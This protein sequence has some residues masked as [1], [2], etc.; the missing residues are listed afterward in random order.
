MDG[1]RAAVGKAHSQITE[2]IKALV[3]TLRPELGEDPAVKAAINDA[4]HKAGLVTDRELTA[5]AD[6]VG[7]TD[8]GQQLLSLLREKAALAKVVHLAGKT[9]GLSSALERFQP[10]V[11]T[12]PLT[13]AGALAAGTALPQYVLPAALALGASYGVAR[14]VDAA[15]GRR[16]PLNRF[17]QSC[18]K[19]ESPEGMSS[20]GL[21]SVLAQ[22]RA[23]QAQGGQDEIV[24]RLKKLAAS[25]RVSELVRANQLA[26][27][28][29]AGGWGRR[30]Y[31]NLGLTPREF[32]KGL[33][34]LSNEQ[35]LLTRD[36][37]SRAVDDPTS[38]MASK[39]G[40]AIEDRLNHLISE[41]RLARA[42]GWMP[43]GSGNGIEDPS[44]NRPLAYQGAID[45]HN[46]AILRTDEQIQAS[47]MSPE[48]IEA[49]RR[50]LFAL[51]KARS[52][53]E[54]R[55]AIAD[56]AR[57][58]RDPS[59]RGYVFATLGPLVSLKTKD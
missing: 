2:G 42:K 8:E 32:E 20:P 58:L 12:K 10:R 29:P 44:V 43:Q 54:A 51:S 22:R 27:I 21:P 1:A 55:H 53:A 36:E 35:G 28:V 38:L 19:Y 15:T 23:R 4:R 7:D 48:T 39:L 26:D 50:G 17:V 16:Y 9:G 30:I 33:N 49:T 24:D 31:D 47:G 45:L 40:L 11:L 3:T 57:S 41:G 56:A 46:A 14:A 18:A 13:V 6:K 25:Q 37:V 5:V 59:H 34:I 52:K